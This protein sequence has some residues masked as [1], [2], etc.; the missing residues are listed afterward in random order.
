MEEK[1]SQ[2]TLE[3][4]P[5]PKLLFL[6]F[7]K[8][9]SGVLALKKGRT[10]K[11]IYFKNGN[12]WTELNSYPHKSFL[13]KLIDDK[14]ITSAQI[15]KCQKHS[16]QNK[17]SFIKSLGELSMLSPS[18]LWNL[19]ENIFKEDLY[20]MFD[21]AKGE[22]SFEPEPLD[23]KSQILIENNTLDLIL[24]GI[25]NMKN[26]KVIE[27]YLPSPDE[28]IELLSSNCLNSIHLEPHEKYFIG[29]LEEPINIQVLFDLSELGKR[30][31]Q[32]CLFALLVLEIVHSA[33]AQ[34]K[35]ESHYEFTREELEKKLEAFNSACSYI[36]KYV[37]KEIGPVALNVLHKSLE[38][39]KP[40]LGLLFKSIELK[41]DGKIG[42][43]PVLE[44]SISLS[45]QQ[46]RANLLQGL[47]EILAAEILAVKRTLGDAHESA[48]IENLEKLGDLY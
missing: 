16:T 4:F 42:N 22:Y 20:S 6:G 9:Y 30:E 43:L 1:L 27:A 14:I 15:E 35:P 5:L 12:I 41:P 39:I 40:H 2:G 18:Y 28:E 8:K 45:A 37:S 34:K 26:F 17:C 38:D 7:S 10:Q 24:Q 21:W 31:S 3:L 33:H 19:I 32:K 46:Q 36:F 25:R 11:K 29:L 44:A 48:L 13:K 23:F 47:D